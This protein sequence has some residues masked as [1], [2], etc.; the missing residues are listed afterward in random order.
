LM[1]GRGDDYGID[2]GL[3]QQLPVIDVAGS[4]GCVG[5]RLLDVRFVSVA[6][7]DALRTQ[8]LKIAAQIAAA[9]AGPDDSIRQ[10]VIGAPS[11]ARNKQRSGCQGHGA[12]HKLT[13]ILFHE[14]VPFFAITITQERKSRRPRIPALLLIRWRDLGLRGS[15]SGEELLVFKFDVQA[16]GRG[17]QPL[18]QALAL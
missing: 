4:P 9:S 10:P 11:R 2:A 17:F 16:L 3:P 14:R 7:R 8:L 6:N 15:S 13:A 12:R 18:L 5:P 1:V